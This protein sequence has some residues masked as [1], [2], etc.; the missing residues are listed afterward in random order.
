MELSVYHTGILIT[1]GVN[2]FL[3]LSVFVMLSTG[4]LSLGTAGFMALGAYSSSVLTMVL[5][6][7][8]NLA[9]VVG[10][11]L[12]SAVGIVLAF[13]ALRLRGIYLALATLGF[14][15]IVRVFFDNFENT[16]SAVGYRGMSGT[17]LLGTYVWVAVF[18]AIFWRL[19]ASRIGRAFHAVAN[20]ETVAEA[21][22]LNTT[23]I[24]IAAFAISGFV[25]ALAGGLYAH[26]TMWIGP[27]HFGLMV[28][29]FAVLIVILGGMETFWGVI[30]GAGIFAILPEALRFLSNW[31]MAVYGLIFVFIL[32]F[33]PSGLLTLDMVSFLSRRQGRNKAPQLAA[34]ERDLGKVAPL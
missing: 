31:R 30:L 9:L 27:Y 4:Q 3:G 22:G 12:A 24:K 25:G 15:E 7:D 19:Y 13:P 5:K 28:S 23:L 18:L 32:I 21:M 26:D 29:L 34:E 11:L 1:M 33:R 14:G 6:W 17:T 8:L 16:G 2:I 20:D 10:G